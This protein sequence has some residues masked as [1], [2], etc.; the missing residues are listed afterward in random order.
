E[1]DEAVVWE[2]D[3]SPWMLYADDPE[4]LLVESPDFSSSACSYRYVVG[5]F[6]VRVCVDHEVVSLV[7]VEF[8]VS[9]PPDS[10]EVEIV[11]D[12][13]VISSVEPAPS[14][15]LS[16]NRLMSTVPD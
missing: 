8:Q 10:V 16:P 3:V 1:P 12:S 11:M 13:V 9:E 7:L 15:I 2:Y 5:V 14:S 6:F 4:S